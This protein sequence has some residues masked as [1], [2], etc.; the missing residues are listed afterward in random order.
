MSLLTLRGRAPE[1]RNLWKWDVQ[2]VDE[3]NGH[4]GFGEGGEVEVFRA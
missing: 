1:G 2:K 3:E 4:P